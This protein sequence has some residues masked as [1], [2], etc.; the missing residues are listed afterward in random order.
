LLP[1]AHED[2]RRVSRNSNVQLDGKGDDDTVES[3]L[4]N[5]SVSHCAM[6]ARDHRISSFL[7]ALQFDPA[8]GAM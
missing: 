2:L 3:S 4:R 8:D 7:P 5:T 1:I 6:V